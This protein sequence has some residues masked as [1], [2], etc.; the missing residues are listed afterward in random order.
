M[1]RDAL[2]ASGVDCTGTELLKCFESALTWQW[3]L[4]NHLYLTGDDWGMVSYGGLKKTMT[5]D[6]WA[7]ASMISMGN[8]PQKWGTYGKNG[9]HRG[10]DGSMG[11][12]KLCKTFFSPSHSGY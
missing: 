8:A 9:F 11:S 4:K 3:W 10:A 5:C 1:P 6:C 12:G 7:F 2:K